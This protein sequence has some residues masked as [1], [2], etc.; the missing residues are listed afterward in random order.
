MAPS[1]LIKSLPGFL[2]SKGGIS[3]IY[4]EHLNIYWADESNFFQNYDVEDLKQKLPIKEEILSSMVVNGEKMAF[5]ITP[6]YKSKYAVVGYVF[7]LVTAAELYPLASKCLISDYTGEI[8]ENYSRAIEKIKK[9]NEK[10]KASVSL[11]NNGIALNKYL[12]EQE[13]YISSLCSQIENNKLLFVKDKNNRNCNITDLVNILCKQLSD[14]YKGIQRK[15][16]TQIDT[17]KYFKSFDYGIYAIAFMTLIKFH[18][19][20][21]PLKGGINI[22]GGYFEKGM[23]GVTI[24]TKKNLQLSD[25]EMKRH[26]YFRYLAKKIFVFDLDG[27]FSTDETDKYLISVAKVPALKKN[28]GN[29][30]ELNSADYLSENFKPCQAVLREQVYKEIEE[31]ELLK[32]EASKQKKLAKQGD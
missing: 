17:K 11:K 30:I 1:Q 20:T 19:L 14:Y 6:I 13:R 24:K 7:K 27:Q 3:A 23:Y 18:T 4:D 5:V 22:T 29:I 31:L 25:E 10:L 9:L 32:M 15:I 21:C 28:R 26:E 8:S 2:A 16:V 12:D